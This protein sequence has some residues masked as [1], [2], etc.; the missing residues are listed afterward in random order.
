MMTSRARLI[1]RRVRQKARETG[2]RQVRFYRGMFLTYPYPARGGYGT[3]G[4]L[5]GIYDGAARIKWIEADVRQFLLSLAALRTGSSPAMTT[6]NSQGES[7][8]ST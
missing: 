5:V 7:D 6:A 2:A 3:R 8:A 1:A 4:T